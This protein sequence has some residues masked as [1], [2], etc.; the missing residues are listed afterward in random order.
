MKKIGLGLEKSLVCIPGRLRAERHISSAHKMA[1]H[2]METLTS[3]TPSG[4]T[5]PTSAAKAERF[6]DVFASS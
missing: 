6:G 3:V 5:R 1:F 4:T 2:A